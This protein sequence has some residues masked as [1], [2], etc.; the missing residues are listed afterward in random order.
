ML[1]CV[2]S[3]F[4]CIFISQPDDVKENET[5]IYDESMTQIIQMYNVYFLIYYQGYPIQS[6]RSYMI[7]CISWVDLICGVDKDAPSIF[8]N[9]VFLDEN[10]FGYI[11]IS[12]PG[13]DGG[14]LVFKI[15]GFGLMTFVLMHFFKT[16][17]CH[18]R[19]FTDWERGHDHII[20]QMS[21]H[22]MVLGQQQNAIFVACFWTSAI[23]NSL[24][25]VER[26]LHLPLHHSH[27]YR[28]W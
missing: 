27:T 9:I 8:E 5:S 4:N 13:S 24:A 15:L 1:L 26:D 23:S 7:M 3:I 11:F 16:K 2:I 17:P 20:E 19:R 22:L 6:R 10:V 25:M 12:M 21:Q 28:R 18:S 14:Y